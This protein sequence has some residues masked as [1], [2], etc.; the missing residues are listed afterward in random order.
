MVQIYD[1][2]APDWTVN[3]WYV[4]LLKDSTVHFFQLENKSFK[5]S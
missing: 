2:S 4:V 5:I 1:A 3:K